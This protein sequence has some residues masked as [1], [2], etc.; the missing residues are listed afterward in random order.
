MLF[1]FSSR[2]LTLYVHTLFY[3]ITKGKVHSEVHP[4][5]WEFLSRPEVGILH[6]NSEGTLTVFNFIWLLPSLTSS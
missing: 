4:Q 6:W 1:L 3:F 5:K 2:C